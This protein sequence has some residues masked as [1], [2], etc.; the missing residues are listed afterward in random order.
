MN[1]RAILF[2]VF[3]SLSLAVVACSS[4]SSSGTEASGGSSSST[5]TGGSSSSG[6]GQLGANCQ[7][8]ADCASSETTCI[9][10]GGAT[11]G[12][13][14]H[15]CTKSSD[16]PSTGWECNLSPYTACVPTK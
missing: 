7:G 6:G 13:C 15:T 2:S 9:K 5:G 12:F 11:V 1:A 3:A 4:D 8:V 14:T 10:A 16:C